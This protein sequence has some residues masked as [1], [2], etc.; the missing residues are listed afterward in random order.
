[1]DLRELGEFGLIDRIGATARTS[2]DVLGIG[3][4]AAVL[5]GPQGRLVATT[6]VLV[7]DV[8]FRWD[9]SAPADVGWKAVAVNVSDIGAMAGLPSWLLVGLAAPDD[10]AV[11]RLEGVYAGIVEACDAFGCELVGG[12]TTRAEQVVIAVT[13]LGSLDGAAL[14]R[15]GARPGDVL[16]VTGPLGRAA[17]GVNLLLSQDPQGVDADDA[18]AC[19]DA[20]RRPRPPVRAGGLLRDAGATAA[21]D[22]SDGLLSDVRRLA[23]ASGVGVEVDVDAVP[24]AAEVVRIAEARGWEAFRMAAGG[25][26][27]FELLC[28]IPEG[29]SPDGVDLHPVG[30]VVDDGLW[31]VRDGR[32]EPLPEGGWDHFSRPDSV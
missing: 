1:M 9:W 8:H 30:R 4:D 17:C 16:A 21:L 27:D 31:L 14:T 3:D 10:V 25:G 5:P 24:I 12:D 6:D 29:V 22:L 11:S 19:M 20:H 32:R 7:E 15:S 28:A 18:I 13:A 2:G 23:A 26:E